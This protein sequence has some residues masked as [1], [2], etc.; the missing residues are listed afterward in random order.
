MRNRILATLALVLAITLTHLLTLRPGHEWGDDFSLYVAHACNLVAGRPYA[1]TGYIY[2]PYFPSLSPCLPAGL[3]AAAR[4]GLRRLWARPV[5]PEGV[6]GAAVRP[7]ARGTGLGHGPGIALAS[8]PRRRGVVR[9]QP[10]PLGTQGSASLG[11]A[12]YVICISVPGSH[13]LG[14]RTSAELA[15]ST[16]LGSVGGADGLPSVRDTHR[17][18]GAAN[19]AARQRPAARPQDRGIVVGGC[20]GVRPWGDL[21]ETVHPRRQQLR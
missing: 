19:G 8:R 12:V 18:V 10:V 20:R 16:R 21:S 1:D 4:T 2:N 6:L 17:R 9:S 11:D 3:P 7:V 14:R 5:R 13:A 15:R